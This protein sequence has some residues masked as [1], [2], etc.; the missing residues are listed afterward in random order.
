MKLEFDINF[1][2]FPCVKTEVCHVQKDSDKQDFHILL[3]H[4][5]MQGDVDSREYTY[6]FHFD[7]KIDQKDLVQYLHNKLMGITIWDADTKFLYGYVKVPLAD[8]MR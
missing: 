3:S 8:V 1:F 2:D 5:S 6:S 7:E 4:K